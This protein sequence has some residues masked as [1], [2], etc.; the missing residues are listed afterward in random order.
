V[1]VEDN[2]ERLDNGDLKLKIVV[3]A[4]Q[5]ALLFA[6][7]M[8]KGCVIYVVGK[9]VCERCAVLIIQSGI[10]RVV[11]RHWNTLENDSHWLGGSKLGLQLFK[12]AGVEFCESGD[13]Y[14]GEIKPDDFSSSTNSKLS[15]PEA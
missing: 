14:S 15:A 4:E 8:A 13:K 7:Q 6:G 10:K 9:P 3:H 5:N 12:E 1:G 2:A 11:A